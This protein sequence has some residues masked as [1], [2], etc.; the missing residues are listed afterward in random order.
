M[1]LSDSLL[2]S[3]SNLFIDDSTHDEIQLLLDS[4]H[5]VTEFEI[6]IMKVVEMLYSATFIDLEGSEDEGVDVVIIDISD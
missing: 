1:T 5:P 4:L 3:F 2:P 6:G